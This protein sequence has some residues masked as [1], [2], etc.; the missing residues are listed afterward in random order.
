MQSDI[1]QVREGEELDTAK[2][3]AYLRDHFALDGEPLEIRQFASG[4]SN[5]TYLL[6]IGRW[7]GVLRRPPLGQVAPKAHDMGRE[8]RVLSHLHSVY[9]LAPE[10]FVYCDDASIIGR[11]FFIMERRRGVVLDAVEDG[12]Q[13]TSEQGR[14]L[15]KTFISSL[16]ELHSIDLGESG[17]DN[18]GHP[19]GFLERQIHGWIKRYDKS[20]TDNVKG[21]EAL[22]RWLVDHLPESQK[23]A[24][25]H[26]DY[27]FNNVMF[28]K[29]LKHMVGIF[30]W[31]MATV[32]DPLADLAC[33][34]SYWVEPGD[35]DFLRY[36]FGHEPITVRS[37][38]LSR[39]ELVETYAKKTGRDASHMNYYLTFA[40]FK[41]AVICQQ[42]Y[43]RWKKGQTQDAR[44][45]GMGDFVHRLIDHA[46]HTAEKGQL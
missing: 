10:P 21:E 27:K 28:D 26:Y 5:L 6:K 16:A 42:I 45:A 24:M 17:L 40:Y 36:G 25:I 11:P 2:L 41:L 22:K 8:F 31:E 33:T 46:N 4:R 3:E 14:H 29:D 38:F 1:I 19:D 32:G 35:P 23:P 34:L 37:G 30:D 13:L 12:A 7:E 39:R 18:I 20:K 44:F 43:Y 9:P 15:S